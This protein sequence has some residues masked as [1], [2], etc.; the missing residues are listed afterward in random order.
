MIPIIVITLSLIPVYAWTGSL[1][2]RAMVMSAERTF[3]SYNIYKGKAAMAVKPIPPTLSIIKE[4]SRTVSR[5][6]AMLFE[7]APAIG[8]REYDWR[9]KITFA[10]GVTGVQILFIILVINSIIITRM[11]GVPR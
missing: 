4:G 6:G 5:P 11:R 3:T 10:L 7:L 2:R 9:N 8:S 1:S